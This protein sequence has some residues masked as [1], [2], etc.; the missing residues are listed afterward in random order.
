MAKGILKFDMDE[1]FDRSAFRRACSAT[2][3]YIALSDISNEV[4]RPHRKHGYNDKVLNDLIENSG[5][6]V[7]GAVLDAIEVLERMFS[8]I[9]DRHNID[10][11]DL[12]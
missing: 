9:L 12:D 3:A 11:N 1:P 7:G 8:E 10:L 4:F 5:E 6:A 2:E